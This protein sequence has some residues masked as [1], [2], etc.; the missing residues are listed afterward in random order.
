M[1]LRKNLA[2]GGVAATLMA[3]LFAVSMA[4]PTMAATASPVTTTVIPNGSTAYVAIAAVTATA[5]TDIPVGTLTLSLPAGYSW[6]APGTITTTPSVGLAVT[7]GAITSGGTSATF[8]VTG[9]AV[10][11]STITF[12]SAPVKTTT[13]GASGDVVLSGLSNPSS[14]VVA[15]VRAL[16][17]PYGSAI[18]YYASATSIPVHGSSSIQLTFAGGAVVPSTGNAVTI[19]TTAGHFT[20]SSGL[21]FLSAPT[22]PATSLSGITGVAVGAWLILQSATTPGNAIVTIQIAP[23]AGGSATTDSVTTFHFTGV[24]KGGNKDNDRGKG[25]GARKGAFFLDPSWSCATGAQP[26]DHAATFGFAILNTTGHNRLNVNVVLK[27]AQPNATYD[28]WVNQDPGGCPLATATKVGA[29]H[30]NAHGNGT[31]NLHVALVTGTKH[32]WVSATS[33]TSVLRTR[34]ASLTIKH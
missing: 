34:A 19:T 16:S 8:S 9:T 25:H 6:A 29:V 14:V 10:A 18:V 27:G 26:I 23:I 31:A 5:S 13:S 7:G 11:G 12:S 3:S 1:N 24:G 32:F 30:T 15:R 2:A 28:V 22:Y 17:G 20:A 21:T 33:G 4:G